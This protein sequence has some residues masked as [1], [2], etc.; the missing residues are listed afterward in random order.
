M[1]T[2]VASESTS[3]HNFPSEKHHTTRPVRQGEIPGKSYY[4]ETDESFKKLHFF[5]HVKYG[6][7]QYG[8]SKEALEK[9][10]A[11]K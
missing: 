10:W 11:E 1:Q 7:Y 2:E 3:A 6:E 5:E 8:S 9:A 4:F